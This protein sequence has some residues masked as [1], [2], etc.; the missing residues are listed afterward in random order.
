MAGDMERTRLKQVK[1]FIF[2]GESMT[3]FPSLRGAAGYIGHGQ[4]VP[5]GKRNGAG[6][7][8]RQQMYIQKLYLYMNMTKPSDRL[9]LSMPG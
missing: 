9:Y 2:P 1:A 4:R 7:D 5:G 3:I 6:N 8:S